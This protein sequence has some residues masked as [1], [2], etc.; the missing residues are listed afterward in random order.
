MKKVFAD[1][2]YWI[3]VVNP[4]DQ[5]AEAAKAAKKAVGEAVI[6]TTDEPK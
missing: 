5:W 4:H 6:V 3:A 2:H 1:S